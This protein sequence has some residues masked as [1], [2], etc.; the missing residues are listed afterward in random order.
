MPRGGS[1]LQR[2]HR[3][4]NRTRLGFLTSAIDFPATLGAERPLVNTGRAQAAGSGEGHFWRAKREE[5]TA[6]LAAEP[7]LPEEQPPKWQVLLPSSA[8]TEEDL[9]PKA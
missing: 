4:L 7:K 2:K 5:M 8:N 6:I 3:I 1:R 9:L